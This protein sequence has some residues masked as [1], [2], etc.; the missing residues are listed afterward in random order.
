[1]YIILCLMGS[2]KAILN[3]NLNLNYRASLFLWQSYNCSD[4]WL[5]NW[6]RG[7][8]RSNHYHCANKTAIQILSNA[9]TKTS[10]EGLI[11][12][13]HITTVYMHYN[14]YW[15]WLYW[16]LRGKIHRAFKIIGHL[17]YTTSS[18]VHHFKFIGGFKQ[19]LQ[20]GNA[21]F[22]SKSAIFGP[23]WPWNLMDDLEIQ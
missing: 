17:F 9:S 14:V 8:I 19:E 20:S 16:E 3:L 18:F 11:K 23:M 7:I 10:Y 12:T 5:F 15:K 4:L 21:Q 22:R 13:K 6:D 2:N 1:M